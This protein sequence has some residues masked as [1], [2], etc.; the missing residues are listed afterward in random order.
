[1][2]NCYELLRGSTVDLLWVLKATYN[3]VTKVQ[4]VDVT[5]SYW[6]MNIVEAQ[7]PILQRIISTVNDGLTLCVS[8]LGRN[9][10][11]RLGQGL[12]APA[13][14]TYFYVESSVRI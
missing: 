11:D 12:D 5:T 4:P 1:V 13:Q 7:I 9:G 14:L 3:I 6:S 2:L 10:V 8:L